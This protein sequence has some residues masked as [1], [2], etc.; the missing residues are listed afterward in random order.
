MNVNIT[1]QRYHTTSISAQCYE[2]SAISVATGSLSLPI[3]YNALT[4]TYLL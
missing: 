2:N 4:M 3:F 1:F